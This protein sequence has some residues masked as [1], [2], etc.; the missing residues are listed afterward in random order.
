MRDEGRKEHE[1]DSL[2]RATLLRAARGFET[3]RAKKKSE[4]LLKNDAA[5]K[6]RAGCFQAGKAPCKRG[7]VRKKTGKKFERELLRVQGYVK[8]P[9]G[10]RKG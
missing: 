1:K 10:L 7:G 9:K 4:P 5:F 2:R 3:G 6:G 8:R